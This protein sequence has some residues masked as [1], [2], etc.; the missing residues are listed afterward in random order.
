M[1]FPVK[2]DTRTP[3]L[4]MILI[5]SVIYSFLDKEKIHYWLNV[6]LAQ[7]LLSSMEYGQDLLDVKLVSMFPALALA[8]QYY[9]AF[10]S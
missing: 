8:F 5:V 1:G 9:M 4:M 2:E 10:R 6:V 3:A 7:S